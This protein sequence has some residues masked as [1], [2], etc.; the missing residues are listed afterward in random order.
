MR[1][2]GGA[3]QRC[4][5]SIELLG[6]GGDFYQPILGHNGLPSYGRRTQVGNKL[7]K[8]SDGEADLRHSVAVAQSHRDGLVLISLRQAARVH[9]NG[10]RGADLI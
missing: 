2:E 5:Q 4:M 6:V 8:L 9:G 7:A 1:K 10:K 3:G